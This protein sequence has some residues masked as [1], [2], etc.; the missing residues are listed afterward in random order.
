MSQIPGEKELEGIVLRLTTFISLLLVLLLAGVVYPQ[1]VEPFSIDIEITN[2][3]YQGTQETVDITYWQ[4]SL[5]IAGFDFLIAFDASVLSFIGAIEGNIFADY[6]WEYFTY[7][8]GADGNCGPDCPGG[9]VRIIGIAETSNGAHHPN[10]LFLQP[11]DTFATMDFLIGER[12]IIECA[13]LPI[14]FFWMD[15][16]DN[17]VAFYCQDDP[18]MQW[19]QQAVSRSVSDPVNWKDISNPQTGYPTYTGAQ[20]KDCFPENAQSSPVRLIDFYSGGINVM[21]L[22]SLRGDLNHNFTAFEL[23]DVRLYIYY[24]IHGEGVFDR[25]RSY[26]IASADI[27]SDGDSPTLADLVYMF[28]VMDGDAVPYHYLKPAGTGYRLDDGV[29]HIERNVGAAYFV[30]EGNDIPILLNNSATMGYHFN[31]VNTRVIVYSMRKDGAFGGDLLRVKNEILD[32][33][34]ATYDGA[35]MTAKLVPTEYTLHQNYP[36][37]FNAGTSISFDM[38]Q[39]G[40]YELVIYNVQGQQVAR[41]ADH[42]DAGFVDVK[43]DAADFASGVYFY[44]LTVGDFTQTKK[45]VLLK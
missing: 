29:F 11:G 19:L 12:P 31:G 24:F 13:Y 8:Y 22:D 41:F 30:I 20:D 3:T 6:D 28:R 26:Q 15:C 45:M 25:N 43:W 35:P 36:N 14:Q 17:S 21:C 5:A 7:R 16:G 2:G 10:N 34:L 23:T 42:V 44:R 18:L 39:A 27:N 38:P 32:F 37:P 1:D 40:D 9:L 4:G 33:E